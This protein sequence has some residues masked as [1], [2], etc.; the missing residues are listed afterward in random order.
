[1]NELDVL[2]ERLRDALD[3]R[4]AA[5]TVGE[6][7][8]HP[9]REE[10]DGASH[11]LRGRAL[12]VAAAVAV[13]TG[14]VGG[15]LLADLDDDHD[16]DRTRTTAPTEDPATRDSAAAGEGLVEYQATTL[17]DG[18][19]EVSRND[20]GGDVGDETAQGGPRVGTNCLD[21]H[22]DGT[23]V[24]CHE[25]LAVRS[26]HYGEPGTIRGISVSTLLNVPAEPVD[27]I[28]EG[29]VRVQGQPANLRRS[30][31]D[32]SLHL[33]WEPHEGVAVVV[34]ALDPTVTEADV[35]AVAE[36]LRPVEAVPPADLPLVVDSL[37]L[38]GDEAEDGHPDT[39]YIWARPGADPCFGGFVG[40]VWLR[41]TPHAEDDP[42]VSMG[43]PATL[44]LGGVV[45]PAV[46]RV[47]I[48]TLD[49]RSIEPDLR[50]ARSPFDGERFFFVPNE[51]EQVT[52]VVALGP[53]GTELARHTVIARL[54]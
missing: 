24:V 47:R 32:D 41:C 45:S 9:G 30:V 1:M 26:H 42:L 10:A 4:A 34:D 35:L 23:I 43:G 18:Y 3:R 6:P 8:F 31:G 33:T 16:G 19:G 48:E 5:T 17:P 37:E 14:S 2:E 12:R 49:G 20:V 11:P 38:A 7:R 46:E 39:A 15:L 40:E 54:P 50:T 25:Y 36:G 22:V 13:V 53:D 27:P 29:A 21:W 51:P 44:A 52:D 28:S